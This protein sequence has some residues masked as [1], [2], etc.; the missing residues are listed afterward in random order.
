M[1]IAAIII[2]AINAKMNFF[3][4]DDYFWVYIYFL[5]FL[6]WKLTQS[7]SPLGI[8]DLDILY[9]YFDILFF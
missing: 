7:K 2:N 3:R 1:I 6:D 9:L 5:Y 4:Q 8:D